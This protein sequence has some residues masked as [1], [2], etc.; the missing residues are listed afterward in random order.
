M[1]FGMAYGLSTLSYSSD[2]TKIRRLTESG[3]ARV[4]RESQGLSLTEI[5]RSAAVD[6]STIWRWEHGQRRPQG[7]A[8]IRYLRVLEE[9]G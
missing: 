2:L 9:L 4:V 1:P 6:R 7:D 5:A 8:A 3:V